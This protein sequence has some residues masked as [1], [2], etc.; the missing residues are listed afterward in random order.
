MAKLHINNEG[1]VAV[2][3][4][5]NGK[6]PFG[7][8]KH[9]DNIDDARAY[10]DELYANEYGLMATNPEQSLESVLDDENS[11]TNRVLDASKITTR[12]FNYECFAASVISENMGLDQVA[13]MTDKGIMNLTDNPEGMAHM[14]AVQKAMVGLTDYYE[15]QGVVIEE[16]EKLARVVYY[17]NDSDKILVQSGGPN[18]LD[19][20]VI[21]V[22]GDIDLIEVKKLHE[23]GAQLSSQ[24]FPSNTAGEIDRDSIKG[25]P[26]YMQKALRGIGYRE[27]T[28]S[29]YVLKL[30]DEEAL[31]H[32]VQG[33][34]D[35]GAKTFVYTTNKGNL[36]TVDFTQ[37]IDDVVSEL[38]EKGVQAKVK[39]RANMSVN[40]TTEAD[41]DRFDFYTGGRFFK[42]NIVPFGDTF[43]KGDLDEN[44]VSESRGQVKIGEFRLPMTM[45]EFRK[46]GDD[47]TFNKN[48]MECF[49]LTLTGNVNLDDG[50]VYY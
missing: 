16:P 30:T 21:D 15:S 2:C 45:K 25:M 13:V 28:G 31:T 9:F 20:A 38:Q 43:T 4:A 27:A 46:A 23:E 50:K 19:A 6:C 33:Y 49:Q 34:K 47:A 44:M 35:K 5:R 12:G 7:K 26:D 10:R 8:E 17:S 18:V 14:L 37:P 11:I 32:F 48:D 42:N 24:T 1:V 36:R 41:I 29:N 3:G 40:V 22:N 39:L